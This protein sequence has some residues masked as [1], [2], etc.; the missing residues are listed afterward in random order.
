MSTLVIKHV[1]FRPKRLV[2][3][4]FAADEGSGLRMDAAVNLQV[5]LLTECLE[6]CGKWALKGLSPVMKVLVRAEADPAL[7]G[8]ATAW[9]RALEGIIGIPLRLSSNF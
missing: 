2:A 9:E 3:V 5:L 8:L 7:E 4:S 1:A 6:T